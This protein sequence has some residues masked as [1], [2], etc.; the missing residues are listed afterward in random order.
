MS[1]AES[2]ADQDAKAL[3]I[4]MSRRFSFEDAPYLYFL[5]TL[6]LVTRSQEKEQCST[7]PSSLPLSNIDP[8]FTLSRAG[9][10]SSGLGWHAALMTQLQKP[11]KGICAAKDWKPMTEVIPRQSYR[12]EQ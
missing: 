9:S 11:A 8:H 6:G 3:V 2:K 10:A 1:V 5:P 7:A 4:Q 12:N